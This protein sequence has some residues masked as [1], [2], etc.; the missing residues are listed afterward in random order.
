MQSP[1]VPRN[2][3][4][5]FRAL[6]FPIMLPRIPARVITM[7]SPVECTAGHV[8]ACVFLSVP[9]CVCASVYWCIFLL[10]SAQVCMTMS[11][12]VCACLSLITR[13]F[14]SHSRVTLHWSV[15]ALHRTARARRSLSVTEQQNK[16]GRELP[17]AQALKYNLL[18]LQP[19][20]RP[21]KGSHSTTTDFRPK[22]RWFDTSLYS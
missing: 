15:H 12:F 1:W 2:T 17:T 10:D 20:F 4:S 7:I 14:A 9:V 5:M 8:F 13:G 6:S 22:Q 18:Y 16:P 3:V 19:C 21:L 11:I